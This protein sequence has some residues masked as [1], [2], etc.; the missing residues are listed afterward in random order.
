MLRR[1]TKRVCGCGACASVERL[2]GGLQP[3]HNQAVG[4]REAGIGRGQREKQVRSCLVCG[5]WRRRVEIPDIDACACAWAPVASE[6]AQ[7]VSL[8]RNERLQARPAGCTCT[9]LHRALALQPAA[10]CPHQN[11]GV[12]GVTAKATDTTKPHQ[13]ATWRT[14]LK[15]TCATHA[16]KELLC[17]SAT[18]ETAATNRC[19]PADFTTHPPSAQC[20]HALAG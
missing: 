1:S 10:F 5:R 19:I 12:D 6:G 17:T 11:T 18:Y 3:L 16:H 13:P 20:K 15:K 7:R 2:C 14:A 9:G 8:T 4:R